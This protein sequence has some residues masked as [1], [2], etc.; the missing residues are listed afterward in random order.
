M[1][2]PRG[3][4]LETGH[5]TVRMLINFTPQKTKEDAFFFF[6]TGNPM[7]PQDTAWENLVKKLEKPADEDSNYLSLNRP[8]PGY[9]TWWSGLW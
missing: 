4:K 7:T 5:L 2:L 6:E 1:V 8:R 3:E 9:D